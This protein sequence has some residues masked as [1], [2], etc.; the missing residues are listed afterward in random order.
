MSFTY[1]PRLQRVP[2]PFYAALLLAILLHLIPA[3]RHPLFNL[4]PILQSAPAEM[5]YNPAPPRATFE[6]GK[7]HLKLNEAVGFDVGAQLAIGVLPPSEITV[8]GS[9]PGSSHQR[10]IDTRC[11]QVTA[12]LG[13]LETNAS[14]RSCVTAVADEPVQIEWPASAGATGY[15]VYRSTSDSTPSMVGETNGTSFR[16]S[17][18]AGSN[19]RPPDRNPALFVAR[20][21]AIEGLLLTLDHEA[22]FSAADAAIT[23]DDGPALQL[24]ANIA[25]ASHKP[26]TLAAMNYN[27]FTPVT[28][29]PPAGVQAIIGLTV[30]GAG[31]GNTTLT[32]R[33]PSNQSV[34]IFQ[35]AKF[36]EISG[37]MIQGGA[38][39]ADLDFIGHGSSGGMRLRN[40]LLVNPAMFSFRAGNPS[41]LTQVSEMSFDSVYSGNATAAGF[42]IEGPNNL[43][44]NF[45]NCGCA[46]EPIC[47]S[48]DP[49][50]EPQPGALVGG[51]FNWYGGS[52][53]RTPLGQ[54]P[55]RRAT[56]VLAG[57]VAYNFVGVRVE[58]TATL[59]ATTPYNT[60]IQVNWVGGFFDNEMSA[61][62]GSL[63]INYQAGGS[64]Q[65]T[66]SS[67]GAQGSFYFGP[68]TRAAV[69][70]D[71]LMRVASGRDGANPRF[72]DYFAMVPSSVPLRLYNTSGF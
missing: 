19:Q 10:R 69:F 15:R 25:I 60:P 50:I 32:W 16:D 42:Q 41:D 14:G 67:W 55:G 59:I 2:L 23:L 22:P 13:S 52:V 3:G 36:G 71:D 8:A 11:Y 43:N 5:P 21:A 63:I 6:A 26:L 64:F 68:Q 7:P 65:S 38:A 34:L 58:N 1:A 27:L 62:D 12:M 53:S 35:G 49:S 40:L 70:E 46:G 47:V 57:G 30:A 72:S 44:Y 37:F 51:N 17:G 33:G 9:R 56:F 28:F 39:L 24:Q 29:A 48:N 20:V 18:A 45:N 66:K 61:N 31:P 4:P 54:G